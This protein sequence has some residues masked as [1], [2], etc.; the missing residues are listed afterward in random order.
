MET[1]VRYGIVGVGMMG[2]EHMVNLSYLRSEG[3][4]LTSVADPHPPSLNLAADLALSLQFP[5][6]QVFKGHRELLDG[7]LCDVVV[8]SSPNMTHFE[9]LMDIIKHPRP[10]HVLVEKPLCTTVQD[11]KK[12]DPAMSD[13]VACELGLKEASS[14]GSYMRVTSM[15]FSNENLLLAENT[16][17]ELNPTRGSRA[18]SP[19]THQSDS[20]TSSPHHT[21]VTHF[22][23]SSV[24]TNHGHYCG[25][26]HPSLSNIRVAAPPYRS[27]PSLNGRPSIG[28]SFGSVSYD[29]PLG[30]TP[31]HLSQPLASPDLDPTSVILVEKCIRKKRSSE[32]ETECIHFVD[33]NDI[34]DNEDFFEDETEVIKLD[35]LY[36][37]NPDLGVLV[38][39]DLDILVHPDPNP[40]QDIPLDFCLDD[41]N[42]ISKEADLTLNTLKLNSEDSDLILSPAEMTPNNSDLILNNSDVDNFELKVSQLDLL[43]KLDPDLINPKP[44]E[45]RV[46]TKHEPIENTYMSWEDSNLNLKD[47]EPN[48]NN[49]HSLVLSES[50]LGVAPLDLHLTKCV[51]PDLAYLTIHCND[52][53]VRDS[54]SPH[55]HVVPTATLDTLPRLLSPIPAGDSLGYVIMVKSDDPS[56]YHTPD[57]YILPATSLS[58]P[59][60]DLPSPSWLT[61]LDHLTTPRRLSMTLAKTPHGDALLAKDVFMAPPIPVPLDKRPLCPLIW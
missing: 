18:Y 57:S 61:L 40:I 44:I 4:V 49:E 13:C 60:K 53:N 30:P 26:D 54:I 25:R 19:S 23:A 6:L 1:V 55:F 7:G 37:L 9:I 28:S 14:Q 33:A 51:F 20:A 41:N 43:A 42:L 21:A 58:F 29:S 38:P 12:I 31:S 59:V 2:R 16:L 8:V 27:S 34:T 24:E 46:I 35:S 32:P 11:C 17:S 50:I 10:H 56:S 15:M 52:F 48:W 45:L 36:N 39:L 3:A 47:S 22:S 5:P